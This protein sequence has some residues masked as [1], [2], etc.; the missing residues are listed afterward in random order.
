MPVE[1]YRKLKIW[2]KSII[3]VKAIYK[4]T[5]EFPKSEQFGLVSQMR[6]AAISLPSNIAE[7]YCRRSTKEYLRHINI[8]YASLAEVE[9]QLF[10]SAELGFISH[11]ALHKAEELTSELGRMFN[12]LMQSLQNK[13]QTP[14]LSALPSS[15]SKGAA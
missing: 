12:G 9:A 14:A 10:V 2:D 3:L 7:G 13:L 11:D 15:H 4:V 1:N 5:S 6:R 8:A